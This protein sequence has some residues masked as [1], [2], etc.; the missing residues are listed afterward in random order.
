MEVSQHAD[1][2]W[3]LG[4]D[5]H[6]IKQVVGIKYNDHNFVIDNTILK[7]AILR[8][9]NYRCINSNGFW[10]GGNILQAGAIVNIQ[11][12]ASVTIQNTNTINSYAAIKVNDTGTLYFKK[13]GANDPILNNYGTINLAITP[14]TSSYAHMIA[15]GAMASLNGS[16]YVLLA[17]GSVLTLNGGQFVNGSDHTIQGY[18]T[19]DGNL[20]NNGSIGAK[21]GTLSISGNIANNNK[22]QAVDASGSLLLHDGIFI[23][24]QILAG[25]GT[26]NIIGTTTFVNTTLGSGIF[27]VYNADNVLKAGNALAQNA[28]VNIFSGGSLSF[29]HT[30][31]MIN[32]GAIINIKDQGVLKFQLTDGTNPVILTNNG[33]INIDSGAKMVA[34]Q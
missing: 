1:G 2:N 12:T 19:I 10:A 23:S 32:S 17:G 5:Y 16:G 22:I 13:D 21:D 3:Y 33:I 14:E 27:N 9:G 8:E 31:N 34:E 6:I 11:G 26:A 18:G 4:D 25:E 29:S 30:D 7:N 20:V 24:G 15:D 28:T